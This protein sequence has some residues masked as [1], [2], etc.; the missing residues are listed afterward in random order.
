MT[1]DELFKAAK[2]L[3]ETAE[4]W[5][6]L[7]NELFDPVDGLITQAYPRKED[8]TAFTETKTYHDI[9]LI[10]DEVMDRTGIIEGAT[11][12]KKNGKS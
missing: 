11:P 6:D 9:R 7:S 12:K 3:A 2:A 10:V 8:R 1:P 4:T 5:A